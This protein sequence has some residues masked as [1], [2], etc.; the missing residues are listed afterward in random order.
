M[1]KYHKQ[2]TKIVTYHP[3]RGLLT[4]HFW[5]AKDNYQ[6]YYVEWLSWGS[7]FV[8]YPLGLLYAVGF[9]F[10]PWLSVVAPRF[11]KG[12]L[13]Y[14]PK[15]EIK[16][17]YRRYMD[18]FRDNVLKGDESH[19]FQEKI[20]LKRFLP[21]STINTLTDADLRRYVKRYGWLS[22]RPQSKQYQIVRRVLGYKSKPNL[23]SLRYATA[24]LLAGFQLSAEAKE[25][26]RKMDEMN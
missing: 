2:V 4:T 18:S 22:T 12:Q 6:Q 8:R 9:V 16:D 19:A 5:L 17:A 3:M 24:W 20:E 26:I 21:Q 10:L 1:E 13:P 7:G 14:F 11:L 23:P 15:D 25:H